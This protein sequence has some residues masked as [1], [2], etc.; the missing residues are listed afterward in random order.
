[1]SHQPF[2]TWILDHETLAPEDRRSLQT[3]L[4]NCKQCQRLQERWGVVRHEL[5]A[6]TMVAPAPGFAQRWQAGLAERRAREQRRQAWKIFGIFSGGAL[7]SLMVLAVYLMTKSTPTDWL[8]AGIET[9][10]SSKSL[11]DLAVYAVQT[12]LSATPLAVNIAV[13]IYLAFSLCLM[14]LVWV[15]ILWRTNIVGVINK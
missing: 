4:E 9:L 14:C 7:F 2:E 12:W 10:S 15:A 1:M 8:A 6:R 13:W 5:R 11:I 3:H